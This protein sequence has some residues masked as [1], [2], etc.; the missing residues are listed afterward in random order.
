[1]MMTNVGALAATLWSDADWYSFVCMMHCRCK[2][3]HW[4]PV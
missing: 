4:A 2:P 1:V 3:P